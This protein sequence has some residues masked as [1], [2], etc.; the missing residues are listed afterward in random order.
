LTRLPD[1][2]KVQNTENLL[3][4]QQNKA[5]FCW[6]FNGSYIIPLQLCSHNEIMWGRGW[7]YSS[8]HN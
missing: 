1:G 2:H 8:I 7:I 6:I 3:S 5:Y 4:L